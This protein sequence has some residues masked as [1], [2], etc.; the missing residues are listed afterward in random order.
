MP[1]RTLIAAVLM[2]AAG[3]LRAAEPPLGIDVLVHSG[4]AVQ[5]IDAEILA[6]IFGGTRT[7]MP[8]G[9]KALP[10]NLP[11]SSPVRVEFDRVV[12]RMSPH[13]VGRYWV[14]QRI[15]GGSLPPRLV[16]DP[17]LMAKLIARLP[18][19]IG[20]VPAGQAIAGTRIVARIR[21]QEILE[22]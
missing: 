14:D 6:D 8:D 21:D 7:T 15:R 13:Q 16:S 18:G 20:Y 1:V 22:P 10:F 17:A 9:S 5:R 4:S 2:L 3:G 11:P 19:A 12:L